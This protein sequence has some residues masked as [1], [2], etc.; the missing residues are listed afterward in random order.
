MISKSQLED[1][2][3][4]TIESHTQVG[5]LPVAI[6]FDMID[7]TKKS[8]AYIYNIPQSSPIDRGYLA[9]QASEK[10]GSNPEVAEPTP[11][12][13]VVG[14][15]YGEYDSNDIYSICEEIISSLGF[16]EVSQPVESD[17]ETVSIDLSGEF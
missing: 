3:Q 8:V 12:E 5:Q 7:G 9:V 15:K 14:F 2:V 1:G 4:A 17:S 13:F 16:D 10:G 6:G 11:E